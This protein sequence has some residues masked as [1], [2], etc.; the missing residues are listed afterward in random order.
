[1]S[2]IWFLLR[3]ANL[4]MLNAL[5]RIEMRKIALKPVVKMIGKIWF[6]CMS[7]NV[8]ALCAICSS[9]R[10]CCR[11]SRFVYKI[12]N[13]VF[14]K[15]S[16]RTLWIVFQGSRIRRIRVRVAGR[17]HPDVRRLP[18]DVE[19]SRA[20][21][22]LFKGRLRHHENKSRGFCISHFIE[23]NRFRS[24]FL[25]IFELGIN[26]N[27]IFMVRDGKQVSWNYQNLLQ[28]RIA[29]PQ[30]RTEIIFFGDLF[31]NRTKKF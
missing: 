13:Q 25:R 6:L 22:S 12:A 10:S 20:C 27:V 19:R 7:W 23:R 8:P 29:F 1:M 15:S 9:S 11:S 24:W 4:Q 2:L 21:S 3:E 14:T 5:R 31:F 30:F 17:I 18:F 26:G 16:F 28:R